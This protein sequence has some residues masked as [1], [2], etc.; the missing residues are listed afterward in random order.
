LLDEFVFA[1]ALE[2]GKPGDFRIRQT[3]LSRPAATGRA[4]LT[5]EEN[6]HAKQ[7]GDYAILIPLCH[8]SK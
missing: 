5:F 6:G 8:N 7:P 1:D 4:T 3:H 2:H